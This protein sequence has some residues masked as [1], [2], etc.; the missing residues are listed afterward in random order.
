MISY[1]N[2]LE[3]CHGVQRVYMDPA[4]VDDDLVEML[5]GPSEA[6]GALEAFVSIITGTASCS[7]RALPLLAQ[8]PMKSKGKTMYPLWLCLSK[9]VPLEEV[10]Q[11]VK[12]ILQHPRLAKCSLC[13]RCASPD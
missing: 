8:L 1:S 7:A 4:A 2:Y 3:A 5:F 10:G 12:S 6:P 9:L 11:H 13:R